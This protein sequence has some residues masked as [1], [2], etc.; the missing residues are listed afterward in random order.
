MKQLHQSLNTDDDSFTYTVVGES[1]PRYRVDSNA[2]LFERGAYIG[3]YK[4]RD[5]RWCFYIN[6]HMVECTPPNSLFKLPEF[7]LKTLTDL[8]NQ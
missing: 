2:N 8:V 6:N 5:S 4:L 3:C 7:E 1:E